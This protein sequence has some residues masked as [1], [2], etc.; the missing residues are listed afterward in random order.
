MPSESVGL[1][2]GSQVAYSALFS[3]NTSESVGGDG[4]VPRYDNV[5]G[6][7]YR[8]GNYT[9]YVLGMPSCYIN[10]YTQ[11]YCRI[12]LSAIAFLGN[13][14]FVFVVLRVRAMRTIP[15][16]HFINL[17]AVDT[18][19]IITELVYLTFMRL[20]LDGTLTVGQSVSLIFSQIWIVVTTAF[21]CTALLTITLISI[22]RYIAV[23]HP[24][25]ANLLNLRS[26]RRVVTLMI[27]TWLLGLAMGAFALYTNYYQTSTG[28]VVTFLIIYTCFT[29]VPVCIVVICYG[30]VVANVLLMKRPTNQCAKDSRKIRSSRSSR[31]ERNVLILCVAITLLFFLCFAPLAATQ[32]IAAFSIISEEQ[33]IGEDTVSCLRTVQTMLQLAHLA[34]SPMLY[35]V[36]S[37]IRRKAF[38]R[39]FCG[40]RQR[41]NNSYRLKASGSLCS[42]TR[43]STKMSEV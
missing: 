40:K 41:L 14:S 12:I 20:M 10:Y 7:D 13:V 43:A 37:N 34:L 3:S 2:N 6:S 26:R 17:A 42:S 19:Y 28:V 1:V 9:Y 18:V 32:M 5:D 11:F 29:A 36:G 39:A 4:L 24:F 22:E 27:T 30:L 21:V 15:N 8:S 16:I 25:R 38:R 31:E 23:C 33:S 35:N